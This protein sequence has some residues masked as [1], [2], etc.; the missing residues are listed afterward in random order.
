MRKHAEAFYA[1]KDYKLAIL[2]FIP[3]LL[4]SKQKFR[5]QRYLHENETLRTPIFCVKMNQFSIVFYVR[6]MA[7]L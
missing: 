2:F 4:F 1:K 5:I 6:Q 3:T 7:T